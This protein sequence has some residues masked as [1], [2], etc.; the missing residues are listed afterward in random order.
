[1]IKENEKVLFRIR[2]PPQFQGEYKIDYH[3]ATEPELT[4]ALNLFKTV[5]KNKNLTKSNTDN[6]V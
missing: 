3:H 2:F 6:K 1:M 4:H 5:T